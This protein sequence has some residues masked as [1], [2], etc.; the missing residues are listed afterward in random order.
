MNIGLR[1]G[2]SNGQA[3]LIEAHAL[4]YTAHISVLIGVYDAPL[5]YRPGGEY[6]PRFACAIELLRAG[7]L[8]PLEAYWSGDHEINLR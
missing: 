6:C 8:C 4:A 1:C 2:V 7:G 3:R 5:L